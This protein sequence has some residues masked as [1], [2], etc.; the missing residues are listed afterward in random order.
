MITKTL[1]IFSNTSNIA[2]LFCFFISLFA[3]ISALIYFLVLLVITDAFTAIWWEAHL[4]TKN[5]TGIKNKALKIFHI[6]ECDKFLQ[7]L[8]KLLFYIILVFVLYYFDILILHNI[9]LVF[10]GLSSFSLSNLACLLISLT[11][12]TSI[13]KN[14][15]KITSIPILSKL[16]SYLTNSNKA[17]FKKQ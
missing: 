12:L 1:L 4:V 5:T 11:E 6:V 7:T 9:P 16:I 8:E 14:I 13:L 2:K 3:P 15:S 17:F 10:N